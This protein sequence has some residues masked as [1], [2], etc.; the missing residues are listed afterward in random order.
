MINFISNLPKDLRSGGFSALG[1]AAFQALRQFDHA[2]YV[3]PI[4]PG[5]ILSQKLL[6]RISRR[7]GFQGSFFLFSHRRLELVAQEV[8]AQCLPDAQLDFFH[9]FTPWILTKP[10]R[11]Y[12]ALSDCT[13]RDYVD[14]YHCR[15]QFQTEDLERIEKAEAAWLR[16]AR[17]VLFTS[18]W[19]VR[20]AV[21]HYGLDPDRVGSVG[22]FG[23]IE[24]PPHDA[25]VGGKDF[26]FISYDFQAKG[27]PTAVTALR[28][29]REHHPEAGLIVIGEQPRG[30]V[31]GDGVRFVGCLRKEIPDEYQQYKQ[32]LGRARA[33]VHPTR[34]RDIAPLV[35][36]EAG[37]LG[38]PVI[39]AA[40]A[41][42]PELVEHGRTGVLLED[43]SQPSTVAN[44]MRWMLE[45]A[46]EYQQMRQ[47]VS[48][49]TREQHSRSQ[50][51]KR[52]ISYLREAGQHAGLPV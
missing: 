33:L 14:L 34:R 2:H 12:V 31:S 48:V 44:A 18:D 42:I 22:I 35:I 41:A 11:P 19:A 5:A 46:D 1:C 37:Y 45:N 43:A 23:E 39:S 47:A 15:A 30:T 29:V 49:R 6:S 3:G 40:S 27:G 24:M 13:F 52:L 4:N 32:I 9:G 17:G 16:N 7:A 38:C 36:I 21:A 51:D 25:F 50:F 26:A 10:E 8:Q 28:T 20:R